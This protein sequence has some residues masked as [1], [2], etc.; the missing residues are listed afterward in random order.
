MEEAVGGDDAPI[1]KVG[2]IEEVADVFAGDFLSVDHE[3]EAD[4]DGADG[5]EHEIGDD[6]AEEEGFRGDG[7]E[8][9]RLLLFWGG[10]GFFLFA[11]AV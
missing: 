4:D 8:G 1:L 6:G 3:V 11:F 7:R 2:N 9:H 5:N 10:G